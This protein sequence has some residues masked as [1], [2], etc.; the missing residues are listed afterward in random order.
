MV[1]RISKVEGEKSSKG[2]ESG[3]FFVTVR[4]GNGK[5]FSRSE[6]HSSKVG[7]A[8]SVRLCSAL[9]S[10]CF[11]SA[12]EKQQFSNSCSRTHSNS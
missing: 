11:E 9:N 5:L 3:G 10:S 12:P 4:C 2:F 1:L 6:V 7:S 8:K